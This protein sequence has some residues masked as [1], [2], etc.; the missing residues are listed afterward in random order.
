[1]CVRVCV[2]GVCVCV[3]VCVCMCVCAANEQRVEMQKMG[4]VEQQGGLMG[5][6]ECEL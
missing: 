5:G 3:C 4:V 1:M 2:C 6:S